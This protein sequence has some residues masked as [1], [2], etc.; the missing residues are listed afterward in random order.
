MFFDETAE[1]T[2]NYSFLVMSSAFNDSDVSEILEKLIFLQ[3]ETD[4]LQKRQFFIAISLSVLAIIT[5]VM[6]LFFVSSAIYRR[7]RRK[8]SSKLYRRRRDSNQVLV[9]NLQLDDV[10]GNG[11]TTVHDENGR[12]ISYLQ[13]RPIRSMYRK[14]S[15][16]M[17]KVSGD[18]FIDGLF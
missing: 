14:Q 17:S 1:I 4:L 9:T 7:C 6:I 2:L 15:R 11:L 10:N 13:S 8:K 12:P 16:S 18:T 3:K 5:F